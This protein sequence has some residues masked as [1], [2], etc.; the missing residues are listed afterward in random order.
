MLEEEVVLGI[1]IGSGFAGESDV[2]NG[3]AVGSGGDADSGGEVEGED[4]A[5]GVDGFRG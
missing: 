4:Y 2:R 5:G 1:G 3:S